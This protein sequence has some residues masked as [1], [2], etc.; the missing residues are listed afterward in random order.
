MRYLVGGSSPETV[1]LVGVEAE[2]LDGPLDAEMM[3]NAAHLQ[4]QQ[5]V[6]GNGDR[7]RVF[8]VE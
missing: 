4:R 2:D 7:E 1:G 6:L 8:K 3:E 5:V